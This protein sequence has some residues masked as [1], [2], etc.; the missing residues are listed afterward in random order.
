MELTNLESTKVGDRRKRSRRKEINYPNPA[1][2][3]TPSRGHT[4]SEWTDFRSHIVDHPEVPQ[5]LVSTAV[6]SRRRGFPDRR[7]CQTTRFAA[8][9]QTTRRTDVRND[10]LNASGRPA[11]LP[12]H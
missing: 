3:N 10:A 2:K 5:E 11:F 4:D 7:T 8:Q 1:A 12:R 9:D 6:A